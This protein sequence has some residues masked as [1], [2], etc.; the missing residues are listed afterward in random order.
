MKKIHLAFC[1]VSLLCTLPLLETARANTLLLVKGQVKVRR[2]GVD[3][4]YRKKGEIVPIFNRDSIQTGRDT[5]VKIHIKEKGDEIELFSLSFFKVATLDKDA[6]KMSMPIGKA[7]FKIKKRRASARRF[8]VRTANAVV[9][10][11][12]TDFIVGTGEGETNLLTIDGTVTIAN[13][14]D[15]EILVEVGQNQASQIQQNKPPTQPVVV[16]PKVRENIVASDTRKV[17]SN[18]Q[19]GDVIKVP[20]EKRQKA[21]KKSE[22]KQAP[23]KSAPKADKTQ[24]KAEGPVESDKNDDDKE[25]EE[26]KTGKSVDGE[27]DAA[28]EE[29]GKTEEDKEESSGEET[30]KTESEEVESTE[31]ESPDTVLEETEPEELEFDDPDIDDPEDEIDVLIDELDDIEEELEEEVIDKKSIE[32]MIH[33]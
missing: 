6:D 7:R 5:H 20:K 26:D 21:K 24:K 22:K 3:T 12:G 19:F 8:R 33:H 1:I 14:I 30:P 16:P 29:N 31:L 23:K 28:E 4:I 27:K 15:P 10:V 9:G 2:A 11:K 32:I 25:K 17:F 18:V 13:T